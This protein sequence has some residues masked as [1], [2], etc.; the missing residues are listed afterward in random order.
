MTS[1][2]F[3]S[4]KAILENVRHSTSIKI[5][6]NSS[7]GVNTILD[8]NVII[9]YPT[10]GKT[11]G[12][13]NT[14]KKSLELDIEFDSLSSGSI[15]G[16]FNHIRPFTIIY[17]DSILKDNVETGT[18]V[19]IRENCFIGE[20]SII[21]S[22]TILDSGVTIGKN[23]RIQSNNFIPPKIDIG[24]NV[25]LGPNVR[26]ANDKYPVS[27]RLI[28]TTVEDGVAIGIGSIIMPGIT[29]GK[30]AVIGGGSLVTKDV[31]KETVVIGNPARFMMTRSEFDQK[32]QE[33]ENSS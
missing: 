17:E 11:K 20:G 29:I 28:S 1:S 16:K 5:Y 12:L 10:R 27:S 8:T 2:Y 4:S 32:K 13:M 15:I 26:F 6:G 9:G 7:I 3:I 23:A 25:F 14:D 31:E 33:Y 21:G 30:R 22:S 18:S 19:V 24:D